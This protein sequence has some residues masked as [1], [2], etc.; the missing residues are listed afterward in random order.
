[1]RDDLRE[2]V[3]LAVDELD[4]VALHAD[5]HDLQAM[6]LGGVDHLAGIAIVD[7]DHRRAARRNQF[8]EQ[9]QLGGKIGFHARMIVE[10]VAR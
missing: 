5:G 8:G 2:A 10:M 1:M 3:D 7:I 6:L 4:V 9:A